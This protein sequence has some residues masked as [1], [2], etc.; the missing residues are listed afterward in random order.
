MTKDE[1]YA[2]WDDLDQYRYGYISSSILQRWLQEFAD[3][4][5]PFEELHYLYDI[6]EVRETEG[7]ISEQQFVQILGGSEL[8]EEPIEENNEDSQL[9]ENQND[10]SQARWNTKSAS[11]N[12]KIKFFA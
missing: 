6:F 9:Q 12:E 7:R 8:E 11:I 10:D 1:A 3:F 4:N 2:I 5:L